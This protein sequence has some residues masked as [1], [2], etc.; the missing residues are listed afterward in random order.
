MCRSTLYL[1][2]ET[3]PANWLRTQP[4]YLAKPAAKSKLPRCS[5]RRAAF[6]LNSVKW[7]AF[8]F[9]FQTLH[10]LA[11]NCLGESLYDLN[12][13][14]SRGRVSLLFLLRGWCH[15]NSSWNLKATAAGERGCVCFGKRDLFIS[16]PGK[17][18]FGPGRMSKMT[19]CLGA[20]K[21]LSATFSAY[22]LSRC[23]QR[24]C[25]GNAGEKKLMY[26]GLKMVLLR[27]NTLFLLTKW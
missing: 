9:I 26:A 13:K 23:Q 2:K 17:T 18:H 4:T 5:M 20:L 7:E 21:L 1:R 19:I 27:A 24:V 3:S 11:K 6:P 10:E 12:R 15:S 8:A 14:T 22:M 16:F 25:R